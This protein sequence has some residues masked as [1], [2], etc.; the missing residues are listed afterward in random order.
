MERKLVYILMVAVLFIISLLEQENRNTNTAYKEPVVD[1]HSISIDEK[2]VV[3]FERLIEVTSKNPNPGGPDFN[4]TFIDFPLYQFNKDTKSITGKIDSDLQG[5][6]LLLGDYL[7][8][9]GFSGQGACS[10]LTPVNDFQVNYE[11]YKAAV[12]N[13]SGTIYFKKEA[14]TESI[15]DIIYDSGPLQTILKAGES[16]DRE[17]I[18]KEKTSIG[19][20]KHHITESYI[21]HGFINKK[22]IHY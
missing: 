10:Y 17:Y 19:T 1:Y 12:I 6:K 21:N 4:G 7:Y 13:S 15:L 2:K 5:I 18:V 11:G 14:N 22:D 3:F 9:T 8:L 20:V 16:V